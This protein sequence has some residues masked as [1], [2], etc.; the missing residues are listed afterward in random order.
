[1]HI[2][3]L[4][5]EV[6]KYLSPQ[7]G[8]IVVDGTV[9]GGG[10]ALMLAE[11]VGKEGMLI[12][13]DEDT[14]ALEET[15]KALTGVAAQI[16]LQNLN[17]RNIDKAVKNCGAETVDSILFDLGLSSLQLELSGRG[18]S[19]QKSEPLLMTFKTS[20]KEGDLTAYE[21]VN[22]W[23]EKRIEKILKEYGEEGFAKKIAG[24]I[25]AARAQKPVGYTDELKN[26]VTQAIPKHFQNNKINPATK[27]FQALRIAVN[28][29]LNA[30]E[31]GLERGIGLL[32]AGGR[33]GVISFHSLEDRIVK[34]IFKSFKERGIVA[35][36][37]KKP[38]IPS[39][40]EVQKNPRSRSAKLRIAQKI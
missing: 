24:A 9:G 25:I 18:F 29:E 13:L 33:I 14:R 32:R 38:V 4:L 2:P 20:P 27:T 12:G 30:L 3:V 17:F 21:I 5:H 19:F 16:C 26:V 22:Y 11:A 1:M 35:L 6:L 15:Q 37:T 39:E 7:P 40:E 8:N 34:N 23:E 36:L 28:D 10:H 31:E